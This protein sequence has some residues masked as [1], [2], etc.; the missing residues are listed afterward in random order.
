MTADALFRLCNSVAM[1]GWLLL[2]VTGWS[3][4]ASRI[5]SSLITG[6]LV[7][8]LLA[9]STW[10]SFSP[11]GAATRVDSIL[12]VVSCCFSPTAG[13]S[14]PDGSTTWRSIFLSEAGKCGMRGA[15]ACPFCWWSRAWC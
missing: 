7:P 1:A 5:I 6:L 12:S 13:W 10:C 11:T 8:A 3:A 15:I 4:R 9:A 14:L 2:V